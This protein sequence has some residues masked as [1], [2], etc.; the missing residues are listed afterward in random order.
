M[1]DYTLEDAMRD[2]GDLFGHP[3]DVLDSR[4]APEEQR[5]ILQ[6][7]EDQMA[8]RQ[9]ATAEGMATDPNEER[10][11]EQLLQDLANALQR[12]EP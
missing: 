9:L 11:I 12:L 6:S 5:Q 7:W 10:K 4:F 2:P 8:K 3:K 1:T